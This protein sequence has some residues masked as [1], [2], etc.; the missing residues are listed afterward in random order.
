MKKEFKLVISGTESQIESAEMM[1]HT[2]ISILCD[3]KVVDKAFSTGIWSDK[4][5]YK[6][7]YKDKKK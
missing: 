5:Y 6:E 4:E 1:W 7:K 3:M 2:L